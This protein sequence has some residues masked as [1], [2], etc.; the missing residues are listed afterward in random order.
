MHPLWTVLTAERSYYSHPSHLFQFGIIFIKQKKYLLISLL[1]VNRVLI[2]F[3][4]QHVYQKHFHHPPPTS[5]YCKESIIIKKKQP[6]PSFRRQL[7]IWSFS[8]DLL[9][10]LLS[11]LFFWK[12][13]SYEWI[14]LR[15]FY[16]F[17]FPGSYLWIS[18]EC[19]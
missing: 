5:S 9:S 1:H 7:V 8:A 11:Y 16:S 3:A 15:K 17:K 13:I 18:Y 10:N 19:S 6:K 14:F 2:L 12:K 4:L